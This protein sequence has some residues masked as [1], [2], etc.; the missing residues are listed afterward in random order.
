[1][2][3]E[4]SDTFNLTWL[5]KKTFEI[6]ATAP[7][8][9][10]GKAKKKAVAKAGEGMEI[11]GFRK[12]KAPE[13]LIIESLSPNKLL[14]LTLQE[15][16]PEFYSKAISSFGLKP[17]IFPKIELVSAKEKED[18]KI[19]LTSCEEPEVKLG[20]YKD[21]LKKQ[22]AT[23]SIWT[24]GKGGSGDKKEKSPENSAEKKDEKLDKTIK[25]LLDHIKIEISDL[26]I[27][28]EVS[29]KL[30]EL[31][32]QTQRL[33]L[34]ID[35]YLASIGKT[36]ESL[37]QEYKSQVERSLA[38]Q[39]ILSA[40][41]ETEKIAV[42]PEEI[43]KAI[44]STKNEEEKKALESQKDVLVSILRQQKTLDFLASL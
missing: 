10:I 20:N 15:I 21:E 43:E 22:K 35:Q 9:E 38:L 33:G 3:D 34:T 30:S 24:P 19:K 26:L 7:W 42:T 6:L 44:L 11:K 16:I 4:K 32:E 17:I 31:L 39:L 41:A 18:W 1:M 27:D 28:A 25:Y 37:K 14:E 5:P 36:V 13:N 12:G 2:Q 8:L 23:D 29:R 40:I